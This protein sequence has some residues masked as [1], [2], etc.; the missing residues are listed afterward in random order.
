VIIIPLLEGSD[1]KTIAANIKELM[2]T[3]KYTQEQATA[4][5]LE[6]AGKAGPKSNASTLTPEY[7]LE[8]YNLVMSHPSIMKQITDEIHITAR[9]KAG[10][11]LHGQKETGQTMPEMKANSDDKIRVAFITNEQ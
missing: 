7:L 4:I 11:Q 1:D 5:A 6:K 10:G 8:F 9:A 3:G 2:A